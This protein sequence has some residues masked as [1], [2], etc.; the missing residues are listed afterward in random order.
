MGGSRLILYLHY[1]GRA[2]DLRTPTVQV[3]DQSADNLPAHL[4]AGPEHSFTG[5]FLI[6]FE[7]GLL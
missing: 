4:K 6:R 3:S 2:K 7:F 1:R 5:S